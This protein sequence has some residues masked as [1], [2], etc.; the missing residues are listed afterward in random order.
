MPVLRVRAAAKAL[1]SDSGQA[2]G[3]SETKSVVVADLDGD[4]D[5]DLFESNS[6]QTSNVWLNNGSGLFSREF[7]GNQF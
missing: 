5:L 6:T 7:N 1:F 4:G 2:L 3:S